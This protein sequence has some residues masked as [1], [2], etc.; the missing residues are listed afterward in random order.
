M[1]NITV[2]LLLLTTVVFT[3]CLKDTDT[4]LLNHEQ[5]TTT[6]IEESDLPIDAFN[7]LQVLK[8]EMAAQVVPD[9]QP[10]EENRNSCNF[11]YN[12][13]YILH[14][15]VCGFSNNA[16]GSIRTG[17]MFVFS[18]P[19]AMIRPPSVM[20]SSKTS[21]NEMLYYWV[22]VYD[23]AKGKYGYTKAGWGAMTDAYYEFDF[24]PNKW[25]NSRVVVWQKDVSGNY[26]W[27]LVTSLW[28]MPFTN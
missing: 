12:S 14:Q 3:S 1:K 8:S 24:T 26:G 20:L 18:P 7:A 15:D 22:G 28:T 17:T 10:N 16:Y 11:P 19:I 6:E 25:H 5:P 9:R 4:E 2:F 23:Y 13:D 27:R 21:N